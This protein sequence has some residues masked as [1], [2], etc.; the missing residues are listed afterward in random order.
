[1]STTPSPWAPRPGYRRSSGLPQTSAGPSPLPGTGQRY[2]VHRESA[3]FAP[4]GQA[5]QQQAAPAWTRPGPHSARRTGELVAR[6]VLASIGAL[7]MIIVIWIASRSASDSSVLSAAILL[8]MIPLG[9]VLVVVY[10]ID[11]WEPEPLPTLIVAFLWGAGVATAISMLVNTTVLYAAAEST[12]SLE[13]AFQISAV[14]SAPLI[15]ETTKGLGVLII[16][17][18]WRRTFNGAIDGLV[19]ASVVA[20][21]FAFAENI[22][23]F[24]NYWDSITTIFIVR[25]VFSP[26]AHVT[27]T[28]CTGLAIGMSSRRR[29]RAAWVWMTPIGLVCAIILH[30]IW[31]GVI[32][33]AGS[34]LVMFILVDLPVFA[35]CMGIVAWLRWAERMTMR[36]RLDDYARAGWFAPAEVQML[37]T[38]GGRRAGKRWA[39]T[40]GPQAVYAMNVFQKGAAELAQLRQQAVDGH[41]QADFSTKETELLD[42]ITSARRTFIGAA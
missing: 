25:G 12:L 41:A 26:F 2:Q 36:N 3:P 10:W 37:T 16:F 17:L 5:G 20:A 21:G 40:R 31:N 8:A 11:R 15:E 6:L 13:G 33:S 27:F 23:Y 9:L 30:A 19:Y 32:A 18:I 14:V 35:V 38:G 1:M 29:S 42:R 22:G 28:A 39:A 24:I 4:A 7:L 34:P